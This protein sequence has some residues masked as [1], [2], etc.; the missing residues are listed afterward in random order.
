MRMQGTGSFVKGM[1]AGVVVGAAVSRMTNSDAQKNAH[2][3]AK[4]TEGVFKS[5][6]GVIDT[7]MDMMKKETG[8]VKK[9][10]TAKGKK[11]NWRCRN[12]YTAIFNI[13][14]T[15]FKQSLICFI[16]SLCIFI[17]KLHTIYR[18]LICRFCYNLII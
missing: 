7:A 1:A 8:D 6:G 10:Q 15:Y 12:F 17:N 16:F 4:K 18:Y 3:L 9:A 11:L 13:L 2:K 14:L 5:I